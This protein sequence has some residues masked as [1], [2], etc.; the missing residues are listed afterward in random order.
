MLRMIL[1]GSISEY[2]NYYNWLEK[3]IMKGNMEILAIVL[4]E[5]GRYQTIDGIKVITLENIL[6]YEYDYLIDMNPKEPDVVLEILKILQIPRQKVIPIRVFRVPMFDLKA[7]ERVKESRVSIVSNN[8]WGGITYY[9]LGL[10]F[11]TPFINMFVTTEDFLKIAQNFRYYMECPVGFLE[12]YY[13][14]NLK[15]MYPV[16]SCGDVKLH[17]NHDTDFLTA[18]AKWKQRK[19]LL[20]MENLLFEVV[21]ENERQVEMFQKLPVDYKIGFTTFPCEAEDV[22]SLPHATEEYL[23]EKYKGN[24][25]EFINAVASSVSEEWRPYDVLK[26]L[27]HEKDYIRR[28]I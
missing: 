16:A 13:E 23:Q 9:S 18:T 1:W 3:E 6:T 12:D 8:C 10:E 11:L 25:F 4:N 20:N 17:F 24:L 15:R 28:Q 22:I 5:E 7:W 27:N 19:Q 2:D 26:L 21:L 14:E